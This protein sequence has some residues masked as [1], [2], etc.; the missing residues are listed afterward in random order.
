MTASPPPGRP[1][2]RP[3]RGAELGRAVRAI[4]AGTGRA[5]AGYADSLGITGKAAEN[6]DVAVKALLAHNWAGVHCHCHCHQS[7]GTSIMHVIALKTLR[8]FWERYPDSE[9]ALKTWH[10]IAEHANWQS[11]P[12]VKADYPGASIIGDDRVVFNIKGNNSAW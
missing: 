7:A 1:R 6:L 10:R 5:G 3:P 12:Q 4:R 8:Q 9:L 11:P 2:C